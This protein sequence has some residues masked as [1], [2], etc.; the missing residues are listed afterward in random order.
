MSEFVCKKPITLSGHG[1][2]YGEIIPDGLGAPGRE[3]ALIRSNYIAEIESG[4]FMESV[5][6][7][8]PIQARF[9]VFQLTIPITTEKG[10]LEL[11]TSSETVINVLIIMQKTVEQ[12]AKDIAEM[13]DTDALLLLNAID[14][15]SGIQKAA[16]KRMEQLSH[17]NQN[18]ETGAGGESKGDA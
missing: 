1:F 9:G 7:I 2:A 6:P 17:E 14:S 12:A 11:T 3:L 13:G 18:G 16:E 10:Y 8:Q 15:R 4:L 5:E